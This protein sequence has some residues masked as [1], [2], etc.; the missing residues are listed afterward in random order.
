[1]AAAAARLTLAM[2]ILGC[3]MVFAPW[4]LMVHYLLTRLVEEDGSL[5]VVMGAQA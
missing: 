2:R 4:V 1:M 3:R 5:F